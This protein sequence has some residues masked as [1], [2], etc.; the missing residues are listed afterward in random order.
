M[1]RGG[2]YIV[3]DS[4]STNGT[5]VNSEVV[6]GP[7]RL[8]DGDRLTFGDV[9]VDFRLTTGAPVATTSQP[10]AG[11]SWQPG[12]PTIVS[13]DAPAETARSRLA[14]LPNE[15]HEARG[16]S[17]WA[18][19][20][21]ALGSVVATVATSALG[22]GQWP[23]LAGAAVGPVVTTTFSTRRSGEIGV[24]R[25]AAIGILS[26]GALLI[27]LTGFSLADNAAGRSIL[28]GASE[29]PATF[30]VPVNK[31][32]SPTPSPTVT[33]TLSP[34]VTPTP[35]LTVTPANPTGPWDSV[36]PASLECGPATVGTTVTCGPVILTSTGTLPLRVAR[37][38]LSDGG[39]DYRVAFTLTDCLRSSPLPPQATCRIFVEFT[40]T[41][42]GPRNGTLVIHQNIPAPDTGTR[43]QLFGTG[44][45]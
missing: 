10:A 45:P 6:S 26:L 28:P 15:L 8:A 3:Q 20:L 19:L 32:A 27:S 16:F 33:P 1:F 31:T 39:A 18:L 5:R 34:S 9:A 36:E 41:A 30:P 13:A 12:L 2:G 38:Q 25:Y 42:L 40:P 7:R 35:S 43:V 44:N 4:G 24:V 17:V 23:T 22:G 14:A 29:R 37:F 21:A 11:E